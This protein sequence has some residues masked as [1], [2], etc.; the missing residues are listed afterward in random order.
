ML[1][2]SS[3]ERLLSSG[4]DSVRLRIKKLRENALRRMGHVRE[5]LSGDATTAR[6][7]LAKHVEKIVME[8]DGDMY[9]ASGSLNLPGGECWNGAEGENCVERLAVGFRIPIAAQ[10]PSRRWDFAG[11]NDRQETCMA[12]PFRSYGSI[13]QC[14]GPMPDHDDLILL[15]LCVRA[16]DVVHVAYGDRR[17][18]STVGD[19]QRFE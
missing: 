4:T 2:G 9:V 14:E 8:P 19:V 3:T 18:G 5:T 15:A 10:N 16:G 11:K 17:V 7:H 13:R 6:A 1:S 12:N